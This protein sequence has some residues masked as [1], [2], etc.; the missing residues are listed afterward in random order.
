MGAV[1]KLVNITKEETDLI[2]E[3]IS[4]YQTQSPNRMIKL[5]ISLSEVY[6]GFEVDQ[7]EHCLQTATRAE[8]D[9][10]DTEMIIAALFHDVGK[11]IS[12]VNHAEIT[13]QILKPFLSERAVWIVQTHQDF[14]GREFYHHMGGDKN[15]YLKFK[16]H[17]HFELA[18]TFS[19][20][21]L[22]A[23]EKDYQSFELAHFEPLI[24]SIF[25]KSPRR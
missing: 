3:K 23:F 2:G 16:E 8:R 6:G 13:A 12:W 5:L 1:R 4:N 9:G 14:Q 20:W 17:P 19:K 7:L 15:N 25:G 21:D 18:K 11:A 10:A 24:Q 22:A